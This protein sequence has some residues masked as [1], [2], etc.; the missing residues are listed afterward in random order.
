MRATSY[1]QTILYLLLLILFVP[2]QALFAAE[3][4][5]RPG[6][7]QHYENPDFDVWVERF[8]RAGREVYDQ[9]HAIITAL[10]IKPWMHIADIGAGTGLFTKL[11]AKQIGLGGKVYAVDI[12]KE[13]VRNIQ[14]IAKE[15]KL[16]NISTIVNTQKSTGLAENAIDLAFISDTYHHFEYPNAMLKSIHRALKKNGH[17]AVID[18]RKQQGVSSAW[19]MG[20]VRANQQTVIKEIEANGFTLEQK[21]DFLHEN[22]FLVF[23]KKK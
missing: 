8:E 15:N 11:F 6:I 20:H 14:R 2:S 4:S 10:E 21:H 16:A 12:A 5:V 7:N 13:F 19:I 3:Q 23:K 1:K 18:F 17:L 22:Y 9:R